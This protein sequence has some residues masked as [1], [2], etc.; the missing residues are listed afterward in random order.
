MGNEVTSVSYIGKPASS[1]AM[2][3][4]KKVEHLLCNLEQ[5]QGC[6]VFCE[7]TIEVP[8]ELAGRHEFLMTANP[9]LD[10]ISYVTKIADKLEAANRK[11]KYTL[12][13]GGYYIGENVTLG[14]DCFIEPTCL[15][16]HDVVIGDHAHIRAGAVIKNAVIGDNFIANEHCAVG[17]NG[18]NFARNESGETVRI[19][20]LGKVV[21]GN[22]VEV[23]A[24]SNVSVGTAGNTVIHD[25]VKI[26]CLVH[27]SH[28]VTLGEKAELCAGAIT[29]GFDSIGDG[30]FIGG[31]AVFKNRV[32]VGDSSFVAMGSVVTKGLEPGSDV[33]GNPARAF[34]RDK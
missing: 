31:N 1:S 25:Y 15:I 32:A 10:Y 18:F 19:P 17:M 2:Y 4:T 23:G 27:V 6:L 20:S 33:F 24:L 3:I 28:D 14:K 8:P 5:A 22:N 34:K 13:V 30:V 12:A 21:I 9:Q 11:R 29:G 16:G 7:N 26:D